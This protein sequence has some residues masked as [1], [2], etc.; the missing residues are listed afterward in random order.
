MLCQNIPII[1]GDVVI[2]CLDLTSHH[3][4]SDRNCVTLWQ[5]LCSQ[6]DLI[7][8]SWNI[9][10]FST[11]PYAL[12]S[13]GWSMTLSLI[14]MSN[15]F[16]GWHVTLRAMETATT[17]GRQWLIKKFS[18]KY[19]H[20]CKEI[21]EKPIKNFQIVCLM[22]AFC[23]LQAPKQCHAYP[24]QRREKASFNS[25]D[26]KRWGRGNFLTDELLQIDD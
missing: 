11:S 16:F 3:S 10:F 17:A 24:K 8:L 21:H 19:T 9:F 7:S 15:I 1:S 18:I 22:S 2:P 23:F 6:T 20:I 5:K 26:A 25:Q 4:L 14:K 12:I 13:K